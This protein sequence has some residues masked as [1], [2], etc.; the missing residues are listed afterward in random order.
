MVSIIEKILTWTVSIVLI[1]IV[2]Y[3]FFAAY[4]VLSSPNK[5]G[6]N[7][8]P[9]VATLV[10]PI[11]ITDSA[12]VFKLSGNGKL[13]LENRNDTL[14]PIFTLVENGI[15]KWTL[16]TDIKNMPNYEGSEIREINHLT[17]V[18]DA[19]LIELHFYADWD[20]GFEQGKMTINRKSGK[21]Y[22]CLSW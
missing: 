17:V 6:L 20:C 8:G 10:N 14:S 9:F 1:A 11:P 12:Q 19:D 4:T 13:I 16:D 18:K 22:F 2:G 3:V 7:D 15:T 21:N 5:C